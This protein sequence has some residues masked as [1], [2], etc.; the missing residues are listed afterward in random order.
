MIPSRY[1]LRSLVVRKTTTFATAL[2]IALVVFV[3]VVFVLASAPM[4]S[5][6]IRNTLGKSGAVDRAID[7]R[8]GADSE[9]SSNIETRLVNLILAA[10][11]QGRSRACRSVRASSS[12]RAS[13]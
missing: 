7:M 6:G 11:G 9:I 12:R 8:K 4:L 1:N 13:T 10:P 5:A 2:G 3:L